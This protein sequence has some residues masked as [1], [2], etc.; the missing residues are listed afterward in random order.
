MKHN[1]SVIYKYSILNRINTVSF[2]VLTGVFLLVS[3]AVSL[4]P[5]Y[6]DSRDE[7][8]KV[9]IISEEENS[10]TIFESIGTELYGEVAFE[11]T[12]SNEG[13]EEDFE[14]VLDI[15]NYKIYSYDANLSMG[16]ESMIDILFSQYN[17]VS[18]AESLELTKED[19][20]RLLTPPESEFVNLGDKQGSTG[21]GSF[22]WFF[23]YGY[24]IL[25]MLVLMISSQF[26]GQE[27]MEEKTTRA[28]E[29]I[30]TSV[31][32]GTHMLAK[33]L[34]NMTY[35]FILISEGIIF[36]SIGSSLAKLIFPDSNIQTMSMIIDGVKGMMSDSDMSLNLYFIIFAFVVLFVLTV[37]TLLTFVSSIASSVT[38]VEEFQNTFSI[39][40]SFVMVCYMSSIFITSIDVRI[41]LSYVPIMNFFMIPSLLLSGN[42]GMISVSIS[43]VLSTIFFIIVYMLSIKVYRVGVLNYSAKGVIKV[44]KQAFGLKIK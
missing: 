19:L 24:T 31:S 9:G 34:S 25:G 21:L 1:F 8:T 41:I 13:F 5:A 20:A 28:M 10:F 15:D 38:T 22:T 17:T 6:I 42:I 7:Q 18:I 11:K 14:F 36:S 35:I 4:V 26:L 43:L 2:K 30:I 39:A 16:D 12:T 44:F 27:I 23:N 29:V 40:T 32:S 33:I 3:L 37:I